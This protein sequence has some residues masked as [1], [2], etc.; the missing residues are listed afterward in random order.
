MAGTLYREEEVYS[1]SISLSATPAEGAEGGIASR[2]GNKRKNRGIA[3][4]YNIN[5]P[6]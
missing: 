4:R 5:R 1:F 6:K 2:R 3:M